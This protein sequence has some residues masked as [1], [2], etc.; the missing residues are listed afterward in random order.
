MGE[1]SYLISLL[2]KDLRKSYLLFHS[3]LNEIHQN[4][5]FSRF[6]H[7]YLNSVKVKFLMLIAEK[8]QNIMDLYTF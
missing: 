6:K 3:F 4:E 2:Y 8:K 7:V 1:K 5:P